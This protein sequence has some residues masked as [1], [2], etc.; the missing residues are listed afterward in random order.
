MRV[1]RDTS[2]RRKLVAI[3]MLTS[4]AAL[5][6]A[7]ATFLTCELLTYRPVVTRQLTALAQLIARTNT[8]ALSLADRQA[9]AGSL[10]AL[11][12]EPDVT[13][14]CIYTEDGRPLAAYLRDESRR[15][16]PHRPGRVG[17]R[18]TDGH[19]ELFE[20]VMLNGGRIGTVYLERDLREMYAR[21]TRYAVITLGVL[22]F[23]SLVALLLSAR[24][25][26]VI[27]QPILALAA[28]ASRVSLK[29]DYT[30]RASNRGHDEIGLLVKSFNGMMDQIQA[31]NL[32]LAEAQNALERHV[33]ELCDEIAGRQRIEEEMLAAQKAAEASSLAKSVFLANMSHEL[34]TPL[35]AIIGYSEM[36]REDAELCGNLD[37]AADLGRITSAGRHLLSLINSVLDLSKVEAGKTELSWE[38]VPVAQVLEEA[39]GAMAPLARKNHNQLIVNCEPGLPPMHV[40]LIKFR[41]SLYNLVGNACKFTKNGTVSIEVAPATAA[42]AEWIEWR[43]RDTGIGIA[44]GELGR[45]FQPFTQVDAST[46][47]KFGGTGLGLAISQRFCRLMGGAIVVASQPGKGST[48]TIRLPYGRPERLELPV[49]PVVE[50]MAGAGDGC[51]RSNT[52]LVI[53]DDPT[54][55]DLMAR[56]LRKEGF[57]V[58]LASTGL[59][60]L[61]LARAARPAA[62]TLDIFMPEMNGWA[63]LSTLRTDSDLMDIPVI[64]VTVSDDRQRACLLGAADFLQKPIEPDVLVAALKRRMGMLSGTVLVVDDDPASRDMTGRALRRHFASVIEAADGPTALE[65]L[66]RHRVGLILLDLMMPGMDG[67]DFLR[68]VREVDAWRRIPVVV[69]TAKD[70]TPEDRGRLPG[71]R[72][73]L[74]KGDGGSVGLAREIAD[75]ISGCRHDAATPVC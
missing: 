2:I 63:V 3:I 42:G 44:A 32:D 73:I 33:V 25:Q 39:V 50:T 74:H 20:P 64:L 51:P 34:R 19:L 59:E 7:C 75:L 41:Q 22:L 71:V 11:R 38:D 53:D 37:C 15:N 12:A 26:A 30:L 17:A 72:Q 5:M 66:S 13:A 62:I 70:I 1:F 27:S 55:H 57:Q 24:L 21:L 69:L 67:F 54:V 46:S 45:L 9:A 49:A 52:I 4:T 14:A 47:R 65:G 43:V 35:N 48:F 61:R 58:L 16:L 29:R 23:S 40:D 60:G 18:I 28:I 56:L 10:A 6:L 36:L 31:R 8:A 68:A